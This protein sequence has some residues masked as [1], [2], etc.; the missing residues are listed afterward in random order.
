MTT[1][2]ALAERFPPEWHKQRQQGG[3]TLT[4]VPT[5]KIIERLN[6]VL[7]TAWSWAVHKCEINPQDKFAIAHG[8]LSYHVDGVSY[9]K[10]G[11]GMGQ[12]SSAK[13]ELDMLLK[14]ANSE[15]LKN[16]AK[17]LG[18]GLYLYDE[19]ERKEVEADM[20]RPKPRQPAP[21]AAPTETPWD[22]ASKRLRAIAGAV[23]KSHGIKAAD[24]G[25]AVT[26]LLG[27]KSS[28]DC[29]P[30]ELHQL[31]DTIEADA[32]TLIAGHQAA[33]GEEDIPTFEPA[34]VAG[35]AA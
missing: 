15:A 1:H 2:A 28:K 12:N 24:V 4:Y 23:G 11:V 14:T 35:G 32:G 25:A 7:G 10:D 27:G 17:L 26:S 18:V 29:T 33:I 16:A 19:G 9:S 3:Q 34:T 13:V 21:S 6:A 5:D 8:T 31:A 30:D 22:K 20:R